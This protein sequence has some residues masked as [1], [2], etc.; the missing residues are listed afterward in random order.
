MGSVSGDSA[1]SE[2][3]SEDEEASVLD[4]PDPM[5]YTTIDKVDTQQRSQRTEM[6]RLLESAGL[7]VETQPVSR[8]RRRP[9][10]PPPRMIFDPKDHPDD[11]P[12]GETRAPIENTTAQS[13]YPS[14]AYAFAADDAYSRWQNGVVGGLD[15]AALHVRQWDNTR[16]PAESARGGYS[17]NID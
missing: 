17:H 13:P 15:S 14:A 11:S 6:I 16:E 9:P 10:P 5:V 12:A 3:S 4:T 7:R 8:D 1:D 2:D